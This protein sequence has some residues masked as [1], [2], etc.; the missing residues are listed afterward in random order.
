M[1][2]L[3]IEHV[4]TVVESQVK[5]LL[6]QPGGEATLYHRLHGIFISEGPDLIGE[7]RHLLGEGERSEIHDM[8]HNIKGSSA[9][10]GAKRINEL[11]AYAVQVC[12]EDGDLEQL[13]ELPDRIEAEYSQ[14]DSETQRFL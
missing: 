12:R 13:T 11:A 2:S 1:S 7:L 6:D 14:Y 9:A 4:E 5:E 3:D 10:M 8:F